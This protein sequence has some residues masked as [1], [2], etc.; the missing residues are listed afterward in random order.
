MSTLHNLYHDSQATNKRRASRMGK[1][2]PSSRAKRAPD[3]DAHRVMKKSVGAVS[4]SLQKIPLRRIDGSET[5]LAE[6]DGKV[7]LVVNVA[8]EC[9]LTPQYAG[10]ETLYERYRDRGLVV[11]GFPANEFGAQEP[12]TNSEI[13]TFCETSFGVQFPMFEKIVV[14]GD[15][16][17][18]LYAELTTVQPHAQ[19]KPDSTL[20]EKLEKG[21]RLAGSRDNDIMWNFEK[22]VIG[23]HG[24]VVARIAPDVTPEDSLLVGII[25]AELA[26]T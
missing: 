1:S 19:A 24:D 9:G 14:K 25:E 18:P 2:S 6:F 8:S 3:K 21:G 13:A 26:K 22:F 11:L 20:R 5:N 15:G 12:G 10:L 17:H 7:A 16:Q 23:R 4:D